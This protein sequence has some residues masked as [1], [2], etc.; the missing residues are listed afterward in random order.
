[1]QNAK[2]QEYFF[3]DLNI[4]FMYNEFCQFNKESVKRM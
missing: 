3:L 1:M 4:I 2:I